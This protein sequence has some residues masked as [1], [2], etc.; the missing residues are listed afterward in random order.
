VVTAILAWMLSTGEVD[1]ACGAKPSADKP[2]L[3]AQHGEG[4][5]QLLR[6]GPVRLKAK[7][8]AA[9]SPHQAPGHVG[10]PG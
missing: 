2:W 9:S 6:P 10:S 8:R 3:E 4:P 5:D 1:G 7:V